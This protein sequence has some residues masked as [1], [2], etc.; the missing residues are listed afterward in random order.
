[1]SDSQK[2]LEKAVKLN[3]F[4]ATSRHL[5]AGI[6]RE[7]GDSRRVERL[8]EISNEGAELRRLVLQAPSAHVD[9]EIFSR[10]KDY[11]AIC[12][13]SDIADA[14]A[15]RLQIAPAEDFFPSLS[16]TP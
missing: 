11:A 6:L 4:D 7:M 16:P 8:E 3:P 5:L 9:S 14:M 15:K 1:M 13:Q 2:A 10:I 12:G